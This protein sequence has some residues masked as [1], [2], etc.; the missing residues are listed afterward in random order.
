V[1]VLVVVIG[2]LV[3]L[4]FLA[5]VVG[6]RLVQWGDERR[7]E[8]P[9]GLADIVPGGRSTTVATDDGAELH[10]AA[11]GAGP[12][13]V[14]VHG[15]ALDHRTWHHQYV[16][17]A[18]RFRLIGIDLRGHGR[19]KLGDEPFGPHRSAADIGAVLERLDLRSVVLVGHSLGGT[20][21]GQ[22]CA[23][24]PDVIRERVA[25]LVFVGTFASA[26]AGEGRLRELFSPTMIRLAARFQTK[27]EPRGSASTSPLAYAMARQPFGPHPQPEQV[28]HTLAMGA[29][30]APAVVSAA[31]VANL[32]YDVRE[33]LGEVACP[34]LVVR[35]EHDSLAT[36]RSAHQLATAMPAAEVVVIEG[37]GH[38]PML[39]ARERF[40]ELLAGFASKVTGNTGGARG[41]DQ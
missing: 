17:L 37:S 34:V 31:T 33:D 14:L 7:A 5:T 19:S 9:S 20:I 6:P 8:P 22:L 24:R 12:P 27:T 39:E 21:L 23:D 10:V 35:G 25:G 4:A 36:E 3:V 15:L 40:T 30:C 29:A 16:D 18:D 38:L 13:V 1:T 32:D 2:I 11:W 26:I 41:E 28:R